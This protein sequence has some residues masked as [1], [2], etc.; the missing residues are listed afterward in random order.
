ME[1]LYEYLTA[2]SRRGDRYGEN[3]GILDLLSWCGKQ[4]TQDVTLEEARRFYSDPHQPY[5]KP[6]ASKRE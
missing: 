6:E 3:G 5:A 1:Q 2:I 4:N